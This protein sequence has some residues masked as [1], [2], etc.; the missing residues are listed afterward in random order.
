[1][2]TASSKARDQQQRRR[3]QGIAVAQ[4]E[5]RLETGRRSPPGTVHRAIAPGTLSPIKTARSKK[6]LTKRASEAMGCSGRKAAKKRASLLIRPSSAGGLAVEVGGK[7]FVQAGEARR[8]EAEAARARQQQAEQAEE[9]VQTEQ[10]EAEQE[11]ASSVDDATA[12]TN[13]VDVAGREGRCTPT[14]REREPEEIVSELATPHRQPCA[15]D[16]AWMRRP[17]PLAAKPQKED[18]NRGSVGVTDVPRSMAPRRLGPLA[19]LRD[20]HLSRTP[21]LKKLPAPRGRRHQSRSTAAHAPPGG[22][23]LDM[24]AR[25]TVQNTGPPVPSIGWAQTEQ[26]AAR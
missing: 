6:P 16:P 8:R 11:A 13:R 4:A 24:D 23:P 5:K 1:M 3:A 26:P 9:A 14:E 22:I 7:Q 19:P 2:G 25:D 21:R 17:T 20:Q 12:E 18:E 15:N 10:A